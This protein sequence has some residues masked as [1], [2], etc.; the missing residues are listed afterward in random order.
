MIEDKLQN[1]SSLT[2][3]EMNTLSGDLYK[4]WDDE[5]NSI[6]ARLKEKLDESTMDQLTQEE[7]QWISDKDEQVEAAGKEAE[8]GSLQPLL[9]ND[10]AAEITKARVYELAQYLR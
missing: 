8:G 6:W 3:S 4:L 9:E 2:Q 7:R 1:D 10:E 5:L